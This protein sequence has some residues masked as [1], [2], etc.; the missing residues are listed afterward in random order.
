[1]K[2]SKEIFYL[3]LS[4]PINDCI[5]NRPSPNTCK[6]A[7]IIPIFKNDSILLCTNCRPIFL[8]SHISTKFW[9]SDSQYIKLL[10]EQHNHLYLYQFG[11]R[12]N[13]LTNESLM[14]IVEKIQKQLDAENYT[15]AGAFADL[16]KALDQ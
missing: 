13:Y 4:Q 8:F 5:S 2:I 3:L 14:A 15:T 1:M 9:K 7:Q 16:T 11:F 6:L 10:L 12:I